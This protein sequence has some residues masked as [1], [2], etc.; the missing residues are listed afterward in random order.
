MKIAILGGTFNPVHIGHLCLA[1]EVATSLGY[2]KIL[3]VPVNVPPH[4]ILKD[5]A[6]AEQRIGMLRAATENDERFE[7]ET[8]EIDR[9]GLSY[10]IDTV[11]YLYEKY[12]GSLEGKIGLIMGQEIAGEFYKWK[13]ADELAKLTTII[14][15][16]R[17]LDTGGVDTTAFENKSAGNYTGDVVSDDVF[18]NF[19]YDFINLENQVLPVSSTEIRTR[20]ATNKAWKYLV[21]QSVFEYICEGKIYKAN[22]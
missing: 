12:A 2:N 20:V 4:K 17:K 1:D 11:K 13:G 6:T 7:V 21:P 15:A 14:I 22:V 8:C 3:F 19:S 5:A 16:H 10:T 18:E 9:G